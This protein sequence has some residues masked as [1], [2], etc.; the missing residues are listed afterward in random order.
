MAEEEKPKEGEAPAEDAGAKKK[1]MMLMIGMSLV[2]IP[3]VLLLG[4]FVIR[5][6]IAPE[7]P[8]VVEEPVPE[9]GLIMMFEDITVNVTANR[10]SKFLRLK[11]GVEYEDP[12]TEAELAERT[13]EIRDLVISAISGR[14]A[15]QLIS[16][17]GKK[18]LKDELKNRIDTT[19]QEG[20]VM[21]VYFS[22][23]VIQ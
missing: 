2:Q 20:G 22:E 3:I 19:V 10:G 12:K 9:R 6:M 4:H 13:P 15:E 14:S 7:N 17:E 16:A 5:P 11:M 18:Q 23:F 21:N 1:R 8:E